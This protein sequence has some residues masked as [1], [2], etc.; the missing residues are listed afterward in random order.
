MVNG[1][2]V[3]DFCLPRYYDVTTLMGPAACSFTGAITAP[4]QIL[5]NGY[6][7]W[8]TDTRMLVQ[9]AADQDGVPTTTTLGP[10]TDR[11]PRSLREHAD[12]LD[13]RQRCLS[14]ATL[15]AHLRTA[16]DAAVVARQKRCERLISAL[17]LHC[18]GP[19]SA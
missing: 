1:V 19:A 5:R 13:P 14:R 12:A 6:V 16:R 2:V 11:G 7:N 4:G 9:C 10:V 3:S 17:D 15:P 18:A 8:I